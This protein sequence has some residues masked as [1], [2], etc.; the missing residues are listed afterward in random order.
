RMFVRNL[1]T[2]ALF[3]AA[4]VGAGLRLAR[5]PQPA[6]PPTEALR[7][8][9]RGAVRIVPLGDVDWIGAAGNYAEAHTGQGSVLLDESLAAL[10]ARLPADAFARIHRGVIVRLDRIAQV[11]GLGRGD[12]QVTLRS[13]AELRLS[14]RYR[15][16]LSAW[17]NGS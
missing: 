15:P 13:G 12:A 7:A 10:A 9:S 3:Y 11:K 17:L 1:G 14:R 16:A 2:N 4:L 5:R 6:P 8:R